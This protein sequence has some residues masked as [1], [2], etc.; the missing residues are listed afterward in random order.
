MSKPI[1]SFILYVLLERRVQPVTFLR[2]TDRRN[3]AIKAY[4]PV[5]M[6][7]AKNHEPSGNGRGVEGEGGGGGGGGGGI[8]FTI[9][10]HHKWHCQCN[11]DMFK[12]ICMCLEFVYS[13]CAYV[14]FQ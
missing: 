9:N 8:I 4:V 14:G 10:F 13:S 5:H 7:R 2:A 1:T 12:A 11:A 6:V 3:N